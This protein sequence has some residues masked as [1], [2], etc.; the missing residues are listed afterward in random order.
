MVKANR[1]S[2]IHMT[3]L[4][5]KPVTHILTNAMMRKLHGATRPSERSH[6]VPDLN[7]GENVVPRTAPVTVLSYDQNTCQSPL[8][9]RQTVTWEIT[10]I[11]TPVATTANRDA[12]FNYNLFDLSPIL[13]RCT[14]VDD[15]PPHCQQPTA[16]G[17][18]LEDHITT[19]ATA[20]S[21]RC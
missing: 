13:E 14:P 21:G 7:T 10:K 20:T 15:V 16:V 6:V 2:D 5:L 3:H 4:F 12:P 19:K 1:S 9:D 11:H 17:V 8:I 18:N